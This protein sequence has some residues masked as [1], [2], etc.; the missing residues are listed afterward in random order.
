MCQGSSPDH[1]VTGVLPC[2]GVAPLGLFGGVCPTLCRFL[3]V[4]L[5]VFFGIGLLVWLGS[6][7]VLPVGFV[8]FELQSPPGCLGLVHQLEV[9]LIGRFGVLGWPCW[10]FWCGVARWYTALSSLAA[11]ASA[12]SCQRGTAS[13]KLSTCIGST[14]LGLPCI[15]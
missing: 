13:V 3:V 7:C 6:W 10:R 15:L 1:V 9:F 14:F 11:C 12:V 4:K 2:Y 8:Q 5:P